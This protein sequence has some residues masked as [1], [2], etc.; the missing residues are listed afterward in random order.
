MRI[1]NDKPIPRCPP[2]FPIPIRVHAHAVSNDP[3]QHVRTLKGPRFEI[4]GI[5]SDR[6]TKAS[7]MIVTVDGKQI[8]VP[9]NMGQTPMQTVERL[10][11]A[12]PPGYVALTKV[13]DKGHVI[14]QIARP[15][16]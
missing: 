13:V 3:S 6:G 12:L 5:A 1:T 15:V 9:Q 11:K 10:R 16:R 2:T 14:V 7:S 8:S 4:S